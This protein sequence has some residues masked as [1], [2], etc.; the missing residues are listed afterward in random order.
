MLELIPEINKKFILDRLSQ[1]EIFE[2]YLGIEVT[3]TEKVCSPLR[4]D[5]SPTCTFKKSASGIVLFKDWAGHFFGDCFEVVCYQFN[6][7]FWDACEIIAKDFKLI[8]DNGFGKNYHKKPKAKNYK[9]KE[10]IAKIQVK[11]RDFNKYDIE[12]WA[13]YGIE[14]KTLSKYNVAP[15]RY[16]WVNDKICYSYKQTDP[17]YAYYFSEEVYKLYFPNRDDWRFLGNHKGLQGYDQL[18][19][20]GTLL[21]I[22]K[23]LKDVMY[24]SQLGIAAVAPPSESSIITDEQYA[25]LNARFDKL[26]SLYDFDLTGVRSAN[27]M[28]RIYNIHRI[29]LTNGRFKTVNYGGKD[30]TDIVKNHG[31]SQ[32]KSILKQLL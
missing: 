15:I 11:W 22:T 17:G 21:I 10:E 8:N 6:C 4:D 32:A 25:D 20:N 28:Y 1:E 9:Q 26:I 5:S 29:F 24:L 13:S 16:G 31:T 23:S 2:R 12:Y 18:P 14:P 30:I 19:K 27:K 3:Y 7:N